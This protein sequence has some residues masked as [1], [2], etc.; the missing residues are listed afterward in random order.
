MFHLG[1]VDP[2]LAAKPKA[3]YGWSCAPCNK[4]YEEEVEEFGE[5]GFRLGNLAR[6]PIPAGSAS[7][8]TVPPGASQMLHA[9][10]KGK[11]REVGPGARVDPHEWRMTNGWP[12]RYFG[13]PVFTSCRCEIAM[14]WR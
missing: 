11:A 9:S 1:C 4:A 6:K 12:F 13:E 8:S 10:R 2:P 7:G 5:S 14:S 3:G